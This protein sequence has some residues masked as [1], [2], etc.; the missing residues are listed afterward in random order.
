M[1]AS[2]RK[3][4]NLKRLIGGLMLLAGVLAS[5]AAFADTYVFDRDHTLVSFSWERTGLSRQQGRFTDVQGTLAFDPAKVQE[6]AVDVT[7][8][9]SSL[10]TGVE[11][12][13]RQLRSRDFFD[14]ASFPVATFKSTQVRATGDKTGEVTGDL[15]IMGITRPVTLEVTWVSLGKHPHGA[16]N[17]AYRGRSVAVFRATGSLKRSEWGLARVVPLVSDEIRLTIE[18]E[19]LKR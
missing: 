3:S 5:P 8:R 4:T 6:S 11:A 19:M 1:S 9:V 7:V 12:L 16:I 15:T 13:D 10:Q 14:S 2:A 18:A 17:A